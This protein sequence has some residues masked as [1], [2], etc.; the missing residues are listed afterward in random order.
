MS[1]RCLPLLLLLAPLAHAG[2]ALDA[3]ESWGEPV[4]EQPALPLDQAV[5]SFDAALNEPRV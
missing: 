5:A 4:P 1:I 3:P 2:T